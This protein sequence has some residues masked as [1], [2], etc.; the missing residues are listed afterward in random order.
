V[1]VVTTSQYSKGLLSTPAA[2]SPLMCAISII[3]NA[4]TLSAI[5][6]LRACQSKIIIPKKSQEFLTLCYDWIL[7]SPH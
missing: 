2:T 4:P 3:R 1:V 5:C 6:N 7:N